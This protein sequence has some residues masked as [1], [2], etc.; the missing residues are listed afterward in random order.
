MFHAGLNRHSSTLIAKGGL[1]KPSRCTGGIH[2]ARESPY[3]IHSRSPGWLLA[4]GVCV[5]VGLIASL[6]SSS[7]TTDSAK[8][9]AMDETPTPKY[10]GKILEELLESQNQSFVLGLRLNLPFHEV[11]AIH[12]QF[13][14]PRDRL[15]HIII[16]F[17]RQAEPRPTW[18][19]IVE[20]L[21]NPI[22]NLRALAKRVEAAHSSECNINSYMIHEFMILYPHS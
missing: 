20:A 13:L 12:S 16:A 21:R 14:N 6:L 8:D 19:V 11:E 18:K 22:V 10:A 3:N 4:I 9:S 1:S 2:T 7:V 5:C 15:L 17:L